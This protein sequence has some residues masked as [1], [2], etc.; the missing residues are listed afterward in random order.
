MKKFTISPIAIIL[1]T[2]FLDVVGMGVIIPV[3]PLYVESFGVSHNVVTALFAVFALCA[4]FS[5]PILGIISDRKGRRP[6]LLVSLLSSALGWIIFAFSRN[7]WGLFI[8][9]IVDGSAAGNIST[10]QNY[11]VDIA[12]DEKERAH[13]LGLIG[14]VFGV[15]F[16]IGP[17]LGGVLSNIYKTLPFIVVGVLASINTILAYFFLP[18][19]HHHRNEEKMS[20]NPFA[21]IKKAFTSENLT[22]LYM[23]W[24]L[25]GVAVSTNQS[26]FSLYLQRRFDWGVLA[27]GFIMAF[28]GIII[29]LNQAI[30]IKKFWLKHFSPAQITLWFLLPFSFGYLIMGLPYKIFFLLGILITSFGH[31]LYR[32]TM[33]S[34]TIANTPKIEQGE[35][36]GVL[37]SLMS[38]SMIV[39]PI[40]GGFVYNFNISLPFYFA[41]FMLI[42]AFMVMINKNRKLN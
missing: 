27:S 3:L 34:Q 21:P 25:F 40:A 15:A 10:A 19:T 17:L 14:A 23:S 33:T 18:E 32:V 22:P 35:S 4:F 37:S 11:L 6:V 31:S 1:G 29:S 38:L 13:N 5:S 36:M 30:L 41:G 28:V 8:G 9:R 20:W 26:I 42:L 7:I 16:I 2:V 12:K 39:G 24:F